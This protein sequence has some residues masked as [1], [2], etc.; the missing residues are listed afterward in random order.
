MKVLG[1]LPWSSNAS[2]LVDLSLGEES[3]RAVYKPGRGER[4]LWD[5]P[6]GL[7][8][9]ERAVYLVSEILGWGLVPETVVREGEF[10]PGSVQRFVTA[11][12]DEHYFSLLENARHHDAL[13]ALT[14]L[15]VVVNNGDR[16]SGHFLVDADLRIWGIDHGLCLHA[17]DKLRTVAW[18]FAGRPLPARLVPDLD[19][20]ASRLDPGHDTGEDSRLAE[21]AELLL[22]E[23]LAALAQRARALTR[24]PVFPLPGSSRSY[25]WPLV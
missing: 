6:T 19:R 9:R 15:D 3:I 2:F 24:R 14:L 25:P 22:P 1:R 7:Y 8:R 18:D 12:F 5:Y 23:E 13:R 16:K 17:E 20:L 21:L 10:G 4:P 11:D